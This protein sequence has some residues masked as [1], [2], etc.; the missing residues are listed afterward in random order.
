MCGAED[1]VVKYPL[2]LPEHKATADHNGCGC[3]YNMPAKLLDM[4]EEVHFTIGVGVSFVQKF[5]NEAQ[6]R[7]LGLQS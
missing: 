3:P 5:I 6:N 4:I 7:V 1:D 2:Y